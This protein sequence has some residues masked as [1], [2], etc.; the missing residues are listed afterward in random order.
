M[1]QHAPYTDCNVILSGKDKVERTTV[2]VRRSRRDHAVVSLAEIYAGI[3]AVRS[4]LV[5]VLGV[6]HQVTNLCLFFVFQREHFDGV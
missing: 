3:C 1:A 5:F 4:V 2:L 6:K